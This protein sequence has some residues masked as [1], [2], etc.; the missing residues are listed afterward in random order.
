MANE[1]GRLMKGVGTHIPNGSQTMSFVPK[2]SIPVYKIVTCAR[3]VC[4]YLPLKS[5]PKCTRMTVGGNRLICLHDTSTDAADLILIKLFFNSVLS[6]TNANSISADIKD[7]FVA[8]KPLLSTE[9]M[10]IHVQFV[11][12][13]II[14]QYKLRP[15][16]HNDWLYIKNTKGMY[17]LKQTGYLADKNLDKPCK[18]THGLWVHETRDIQFVLVVDDFGIKYTKII[19]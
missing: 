9:F 10:S 8:N 13:E 12:L 18:H 15:L 17:G 14:E 7:F 4:D 3:I 11:S 6:T 1:F 19:Y 5:E 16:I 2:S